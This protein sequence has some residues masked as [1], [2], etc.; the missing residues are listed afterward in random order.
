MFEGWAFKS[1]ERE[2]RERRREDKMGGGV[3]G[4]EGCEAVS[5][6]G[7]FRFQRKRARLKV[8]FESTLRLL[9]ICNLIIRCSIATWGWS[10]ALW[11]T[12]EIRE[13]IEDA[14]LKIGLL[15]AGR[16]L[17]DQAGTTP[18]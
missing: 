8:G 1:Q 17:H 14:G 4:E 18:F 3:T 11:I 9:T 13:M 15:S 5:Y 6:L 16:Q 2:A 7:T 10:K 12:L